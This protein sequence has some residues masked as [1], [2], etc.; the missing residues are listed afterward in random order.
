MTPLATEQ[1]KLLRISVF[2]TT[3]KK[4]IVLSHINLDHSVVNRDLMMVVV[5]V[6]H[7]SLGEGGR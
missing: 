3:G 1:I 2:H 4:G 7:H 6:C 5:N